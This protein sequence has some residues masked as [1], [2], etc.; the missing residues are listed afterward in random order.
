MEVAEAL[1]SE[2]AEVAVEAQAVEAAEVEL[3]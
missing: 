1:E 3:R 2:G